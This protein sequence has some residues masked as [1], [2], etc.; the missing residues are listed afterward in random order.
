M[1]ASDPPRPE[2]PRPQLRRE[3]WTNLNG[4]WG[5]AFDDENV[6]LA[7]GWQHVTAEQLARAAWPF[8]REIVVPFAYQTPASGIGDPTHHP[9]VWY[10][11]TVATADA[12]DP[13]RRL[14]MHI[15]A[16]DYRTTI[17]V[18]GQHVASHEGGYTPLRADVTAAIR[19]HDD[20]IVV[21][22][23]DPPDDLGQ[24]RGKQG[25]RGGSG[26]IFYADTTGIWQT[27]WLEPVSEAAVEDVTVV[28]V[29]S[30]GAVELT[31]SVTPAAVGARLRVR[32]LRDE[33]VLVDDDVQLAEPQ[34]TRRLSLV[35]HPGVRDAHL[36]DH[37]GV[38][39]WHPW[40][41]R[42]YDLELVLE[43]ADRVEHD[44]VRSYFGM[45]SIEIRDGVVRLNGRPLFQ[46]LVLD[47]GY[48]PDGGYTAT[49]D[50]A[51][52]RDIELAKSLGFIGARKHQKLEDPRWLYWADRLG[53]L[54]WEEMP[55]AFRFSPAAVAR[56]TREWQEAIARDRNHPCIITWVPVNESWGIGGAGAH[57]GPG[58]V[59]YLLALHHLTKALD[60][61][62]LVVSNDGWEHAATDL[63]TLH[64]YGSAAHLRRRFADAESALNARWARRMPHLPG[65]VPDSKPLV[66][67]EFGGVAVAAD[68]TWGFDTVP[69]A[70]ALVERYGELVAAV[71]AS[72]VVAGFCWT[73]LT[74]VEQEGNGL[75]TFD[76][77][78][79]GD[80]AAIRAATLQEGTAT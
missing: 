13:G 28:P 60:T 22:V 35:E 64:D 3:R 2:Y 10:G 67:S 49:S 54:V 68:G 51:L 16:S 46:R 57:R 61:T 1:A 39:L 7:E 48:F 69:D 47:Q 33:L 65:F 44:R 38:A 63:L 11:R 21:R 50:D 23:E 80:P 73:Q 18:N 58:D 5:F 31:V 78:P 29:L 40:N 8:E 79:K 76:R 36:V 74:D 34:V 62:R 6:G 19:G 70:A 30:E 37:G 9:V 75:L 52:R 32:V 15:G 27:V 4:S 26:Y 43:D 59:D 25:W 53:F 45:R 42:L 66:V 17:Y 55:S 71:T 24:P 77:R 72:P 14:L 20:V 56:T 12:F 41:P